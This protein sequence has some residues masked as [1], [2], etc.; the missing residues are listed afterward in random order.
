MNTHELKHMAR[1]AEWKEKVA[2]CR[3]SGQTVKSWC[4][5]EG[6]SPK[7]YYYWERAVLAEAEKQVATAESNSRGPNFVAVPALDGQR[8]SGEEQRA[9]A[10]KVRKGRVEVEI[11]GGA[12]AETIEV[13]LRVLKDAE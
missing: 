13:L 3:S 5:E 9:L 1:V 2:I 4:E 7:K 6:I 11:Y 10:A 12:E 8:I